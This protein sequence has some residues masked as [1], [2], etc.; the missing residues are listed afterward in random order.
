LPVVPG[1]RSTDLEEAMESTLETARQRLE[2]ERQALRREADQLKDDFIALVSHELRTPLASIIATLE[3]LADETERLSPDGRRFL[4]VI[5]RNARRLL[6]LIGQ[7]LFASQLQAGRIPARREWVDAEA[8]VRDAADLARASA[9]ARLVTVDVAVEPVAKLWADPDRLAQLCDN[10][11]SNA[12]KF[13]PAGG[14]VRIA[15]HGDGAGVRLEVRDSG[16]GIPAH[17]HAQLFKRF[18]RGSAAIE[19]EVPGTGLGLW[20]ADAIARMHDGTIAVHSEVGTGTTF[21]VVLPAARPAAST[22]GGAP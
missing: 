18:Y 20:I 22:R 3:V 7:L 8:L 17:E 16:I 5:D 2:L 1:S 14:V 13:T 12:I 11:I 9:A 19:Q 6:R 15:L 4:D 10:L 21:I